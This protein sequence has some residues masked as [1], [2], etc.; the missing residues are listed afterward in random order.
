LKGQAVVRILRITAL[1]CS[2]AAT[3]VF[4]EETGTPTPT[5]GNDTSGVVTSNVTS[6]SIRV[7]GTT[8]EDVRWGRLTPAT[9]TIYHKVG[10]ATLPLAKLPPEL[11]KQFGYDPQKAAAW[12]TAVQNATA[13]WQAAERQA[14][15]KRAA[16]QKAAEQKAAAAKAEAE[17]QKA[18]YDASHPAVNSVPNRAQQNY[19]PPGNR[20]AGSVTVDDILN[21]IQQNYGQPGK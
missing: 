3:A 19:A 17:R 14:A 12:L 4:A 6:N 11:R 2:A 21:R 18:L 15:E 13:A 20:S 8:Y 5:T 9:V 10:I 1:L 16:E 7:D